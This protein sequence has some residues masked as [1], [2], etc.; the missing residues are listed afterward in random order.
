MQ[1]LARDDATGGQVVLVPADAGRGENGKIIDNGW[2]TYAIDIPKDGAYRL[3]A[4]VF[5]DNTAN[6][7]FFYAWDGEQPK[8]LGNDEEY[9]NWHWI[10]TERKSLKAGKHTLV[11]RNRDPNSVLDCMTLVPE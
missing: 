7:S 10:Q 6:N 9:G 8:M 5:W 1:K 11:I 2:A 4:R 3:S